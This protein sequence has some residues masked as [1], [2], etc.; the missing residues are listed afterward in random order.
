MNLDARLPSSRPVRRGRC[1][2]RCLAAGP[3]GI[4]RPDGR[5]G[6]RRRSCAAA[7]AAAVASAVSR[8]G[9]RRLPCSARRSRRDAHHRVQAFLRRAACLGGAP[10]SAHP[11][12]PAVI[13]RRQQHS[14][15]PPAPVLLR[16]PPA[17][18]SCGGGGAATGRGW[19][20]EASAAALYVQRLATGPAAGLAACRPHHH[21]RHRG[22]ATPHRGP[23]PRL[24]LPQHPTNPH[25]LS[26]AD[27]SSASSG[28]MQRARGRWQLS[29]TALLRVR[30]LCLFDGKRL[31]QQSVA[32][33]RLVRW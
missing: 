15:P 32:S 20:G 7:A 12:R 8:R 22:N 29:S 24:A 17:E 25:T 5:P 23:R 11:P 9:Q 13:T 6:R 19:W 14:P 31:L 28:V 33:W 2:V 30:P 21:P 26:G 27:D 18:W 3:G 4:A 10:R 1:G 16:C